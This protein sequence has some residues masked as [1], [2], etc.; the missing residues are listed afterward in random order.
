MKIEVKVRG[1]CEQYHLTTTSFLG[2]CPLGSRWIMGGKV[3]DLGWDQPTKTL[4]EEAR[5]QW[6]SYIE[7][8][9][10]NKEKSSRRKATK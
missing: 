3:P 5:K 6:Q 4:A 7:E 2:E 9:Q 10:I 8:R 1:N